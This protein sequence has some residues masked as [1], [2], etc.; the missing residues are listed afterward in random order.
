RSIP[1][2]DARQQFNHIVFQ[3][4]KMEHLDLQ[5]GEMP[6][7]EEIEKWKSHPNIYQRVVDSISPELFI[8]DEIVET[9]MLV[10]TGGTSLNG[11]RARIHAAY[12]GDAG[13]GKSEHV[14]AMNKII[15]G[16]GMI[17]GINITGKGLTIGEHTMYNGTKVTMA[18]FLPSHT[19]NLCIFD[20]FDKMKPEDQEH[21]LEAMEQGTCS[22]AKTGTGSGITMPADC[23]CL[24]A[25]NPKN[26]KFNP[27]LPNIM[28]N[29]RLSTPF[30]NRLDILWLQVDSNDRDAD[31]EGIQHIRN[32]NPDDYMSLP[33]LQRYFTYTKSLNVSIPKDL[34]PM[35][36]ELYLKM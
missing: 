8:V 14:K 2:R 36:D 22:Q 10:A 28:D 16:S 12:M 24:F 7:P 20:E 19:G 5:K 15:L 6:S 13:Q 25:G 23:S 18:G 21:V 31:R 35:I 9:S 3:I 26:G 17:V 33:E 29:F 30:I 27:N 1:P 11:K 32:Y 4:L 34:E